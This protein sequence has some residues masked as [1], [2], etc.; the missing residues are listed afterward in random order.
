MDFARWEDTAA[1]TKA[2]QDGAYY[3]DKAA[4]QA[5][6]FFANELRHTKGKWKGKRF[7][8]LGW[9]SE[10]VIKPLYGWKDAEGNRLFQVAYIEIPKKNGKSTLLSGM[11]LK[12]LVADQENGP[13][14]YIGASDKQQAG[15]IY[16][17]AVQMV[18]LGPNL[19]KVLKPVPSTKRLVYMSEGGVLRVISADAHRQEGINS[20]FT[21][22]DELHAQKDRRLFDC[23]R[24]AGEAR[25]NPML[26][27]I[28]TA[29]HD[30]NSICY[31]QRSYADKV[32]S[33]TIKDDY[34]F[35]PYIRA[36]SLDDD[37]TAPE[38][39]HHANPSLGETI[40]LAKFKNACLEAQQSPAKENS[41]KRYRLNIWTEQATRWMQMAKWDECGGRVDD[42]A[43]DGARCYGGLDLSSTT[44][45]SAFVLYL[46]A[47][48]TGHHTSNGQTRSISR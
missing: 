4:S 8:L 37:W 48:W 3:D 17:E 6:A 12:A 47:D 32:L 42:R 5:C 9:Q 25:Q 11:C 31:E 20:S 39:W 46:R 44:D 26:V 1:H 36:A 7:E 40:D 16:D 33:G 13:Q 29:G 45:T 38:V 30:R 43:L 21:A 27:C 35:F 28:T 34:R 10:E 23:L 22:I 19:S 14:V 24:Y 41:F 2:L 15:I 18:K